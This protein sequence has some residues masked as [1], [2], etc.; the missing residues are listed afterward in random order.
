MPDPLITDIG[1]HEA[2][3]V[4]K[5]DVAQL[6]WEKLMIAMFNVLAAKG[7]YNL[8]EFR[9]AVEMMS[10]EAYQNSTFYGRRLDAVA[11]LLAEKGYINNNELIRRTDER[12][13]SGRRDHVA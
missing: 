7:V 6:Y 12:L 10:P 2:G 1:G 4:P 11:Q 8:D 3:E 5:E 9:R 13:A